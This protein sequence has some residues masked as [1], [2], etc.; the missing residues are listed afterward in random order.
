MGRGVIRVESVWGGAGRKGRG[1]QLTDLVG[2]DLLELGVDDLDEV[3][4]CTSSK[5]RDALGNN[6]DFSLGLCGDVDQHREYC[7]GF[8]SPAR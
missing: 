2:L 7:V 4:D 8:S 5:V 3:L 6:A 1:A